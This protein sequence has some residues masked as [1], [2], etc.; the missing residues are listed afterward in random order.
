MKFLI[1]QQ[2]TDGTGKQRDRRAGKLASRFSFIDESNTLHRH[3][4]QVV[5]RFGLKIRPADRA[6]GIHGA[7]LSRKAANPGK[8]VDLCGQ[9]RKIRNQII[10]F[11]T[12]LLRLAWHH[13]H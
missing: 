10:D 1:E 2:S 3:F 9:I 8:T 6:M 5:E 4:G 13:E 11:Q 12:Q 7:K